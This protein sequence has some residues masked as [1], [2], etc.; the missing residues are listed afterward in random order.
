[1]VNWGLGVFQDRRYY[2][3]WAFIPLWLLSFASQE[4]FVNYSSSK[5]KTVDVFWDMLKAK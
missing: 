4:M 5:V 3:L 1:M 2:L